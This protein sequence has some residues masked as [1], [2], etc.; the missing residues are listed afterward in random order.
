ME[1][2]T[3]LPNGQWKLEKNKKSKYSKY[4][5]NPNWISQYE[6][7]FLHNLND[8]LNK[9]YRSNSK[10][11]EDFDGTIY[12]PEDDFDNHKHKDDIELFRSLSGP[13]SER[14]NVPA[15]FYAAWDEDHEL[16]DDDN[17]MYKVFY[18]NPA[19]G[20]FRLVGDFQ[21][22]HDTGTTGGEVHE[23]FKHLHDDISNAL[24]FD[25]DHEIATEEHR[26]AWQK[27]NSHI[28]DLFSENTYLHDAF[29][30]SWNHFNQTGE[31][32]TLDDKKIQAY[33][34]GVQQ[35]SDSTM[36]IPGTNTIMTN[37]NK[38]KPTPQ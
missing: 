4:I 6:G 37:N 15:G 20:S 29:Q 13:W 32:I 27:A 16:D 34:A 36:K 31:P 7:D 26:E 18:G 24:Q 3:Y 22:N 30:D 5:N 8:N 17:T 23:D 11:I 14:N 2:I 1:K 10:D 38:T 28:K 12:V 21:Q 9:L 33:K 25:R 35:G 19:D